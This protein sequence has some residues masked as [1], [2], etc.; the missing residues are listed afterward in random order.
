MSFEL[1]GVLIEKYEAVQVSEK[2]RKLEF[3][4]DTGGEYPQQVKFQLTQDRCDYLD[5]IQVG[6]Q[7]KVTFD[8]RG[9][10]W[11]RDGKVAYFN[12]LEAWKIAGE[13][14]AAPQTVEPQ[15]IEPEEPS[16]DLP[17]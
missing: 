13:Q 7:L 4:I 14:Q 6:Q 15:L 17:F 2:F 10:R 11:E 16:N 1:E 12:N 8:V 3:V 5:S 9:R